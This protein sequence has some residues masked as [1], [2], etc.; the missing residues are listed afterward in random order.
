MKNVIIFLIGYFIG[1]TD[2]RAKVLKDVAKIVKDNEY[3][4]YI[5]MDI[6]DYLHSQGVEI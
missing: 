5:E 6:I 1:K 3:P 2:G 4:E